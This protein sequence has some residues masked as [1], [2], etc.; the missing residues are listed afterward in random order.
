MNADPV[1]M[2]RRVLHAGGRGRLAARATVVGKG[3]A[4]D[5]TRVTLAYEF[6]K[7]GLE[8][9]VSMTATTNRASQAV[10]R[11]LGMTSDPRDDLD[12]PSVSLDSPLRRHVLCPPPP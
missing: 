9:V 6:E 10:M 2:H 7:V 5:A 1:V 12:H 4:T 8:E 3:S 11:R